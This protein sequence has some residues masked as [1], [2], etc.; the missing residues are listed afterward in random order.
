MLKYFLAFLVIAHPIL[1]ENFNYKLSIGTLS[2]LQMQGKL[3]H[4]PFKVRALYFEDAFFGTAK[5]KHNDLWNIKVG[6]SYDYTTTDRLFRGYHIPESGVNL[7]ITPSNYILSFSHFDKKS[8]ISA[9]IA[10]FVILS[11]LNEKL[12]SDESLNLIG[13]SANYDYR[14]KSRENNRVK[15]NTLISLNTGFRTQSTSDNVSGTA[16]N[17][18]L[19]IPVNFIKR[20]KNEIGL[21]YHY[22]KNDRAINALESGF[23]SN[24]Y[25]EHLNT[26]RYQKSVSS[27][28]YDYLAKLEV[29]HNTYYYLNTRYFNDPKVVLLQIGAKVFLS[30]RYGFQF[31]VQHGTNRDIEFQASFHYLN[32]IKV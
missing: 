20:F 7:N 17:I 8:Y 23:Y 13:L 30:K 9:S 29:N 4:R 1:A 2:Q 32:F 14:F 21:N 18:R 3:S 28:S 15:Y 5:Y 6:S 26:L 16:A 11:Y 27:F 24:S 19:G 31:Q 12:Q 25:A 22:V 10:D